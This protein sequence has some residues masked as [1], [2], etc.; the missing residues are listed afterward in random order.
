MVVI[1]ILLFLGLFGG[2][3][4]AVYSVLKKTDPNRLDTS[5]IDDIETAQEF[6]PFEDIADG[7]IILGG[8]KYRAV[9]EC[10]S[11][12]YILKTD[13]EQD[14][15]EL[16]FQRFLNSLTFPITFFI[17][18]RI[19]DNTKVVQSL[20]E[21]IEETLRVYPQLTEYA[22]VY[23]EDLANINSINGTNKQK[24]KYIIIP[25]DDTDALQDLSDAEKYEYAR[26]ELSN[27]AV[28]ICDGLSALGIKATILDTS[29]LA[30]LVYSTYHKDD[31]SNIDN[32]LDGTF[33]EMIVKSDKNNSLALSDDAKMDLIL[34][35]AQKKIQT[36][37]LRDDMPEFIRNN[38]DKSIRELDRLRDEIGAYFKN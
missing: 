19:M 6:L 16:S 2:M 32:I 27:R 31:Y 12:N 35:E 23:L 24:K 11:T 17:Q 30:E 10:S 13:T 4:F 33:F 26:K 15:I 37:L 3:G 18:T 8:H 28:M 29:G 38:C 7:M 5:T 9:V 34:Y 1:G 25:Y 20:R 14:I 36:Q 21:E 22:N